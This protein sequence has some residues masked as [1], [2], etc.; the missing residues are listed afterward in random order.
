[1]P[2]KI[3]N[4]IFLD[5][6]NLELV[7]EIYIKPLKIC[8][9]ISKKFLSDLSKNLF[10]SK[11][12]RKYNDIASFAFWCRKSNLEKINKDYINNN[13]SLGRGLAF[14]IT[15]S[16]VPTNFAFSFG[17]GLLSG[18][19]NI[20]RIPS[21]KYKQV[22]IICSEIF[23][24]LNENKYKELSLMN[25]FITYKKNE[26]IT[27]HISLMSNARLIWGGDNTIAELKKARTK[28]RCIDICFSNRYS[29]TLIS[30]KY[31]NSLKL[32]ELKIVAKKFYNDAFILNQNACS[33]P[34]LIVWIGS[35]ENT[36]KS[37]LLFWREI[38]EIVIK[39]NPIEGSEIMEKFRHLCKTSIE[40]DQDLDIDWNN[41]M[42]YRLNLKKL[43][44]D[45][46]KFKFRSGFFFEHTTNDI[47]N[48]WEIINEKYQTI[49]YLGINPDKIFNSL[50][51]KNVLGIDRIVPIGK[52]LSIGHIWDGFDI[53]SSLS[54]KVSIE[55]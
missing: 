44:K 4:L 9:D 25:K 48:I 26:K 37:Q 16:N 10:S 1:M 29:F 31:L 45:I 52:A 14:H 43:S 41:N 15:P 3:N 53:I 39:T 12:L 55:K 23:N 49:T 5:Q 42:I 35:E 8:S 54:R 33:S 6:E 11:D 50:N 21:V 18:C 40:F 27:E 19:S 17:L 51:K 46:Y 24:L 30:S 20:V 34:Y 38:F 13:F 2:I 36:K 7:N 28:P 47:D 32:E 22:E